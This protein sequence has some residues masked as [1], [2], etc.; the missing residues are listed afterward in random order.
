MTGK[1]LG[2]GCSAGVEGEHKT[3]EGTQKHSQIQYLKRG[4]GIDLI[5]F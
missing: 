2:T 3:Q 5:Y 4:V 1:T